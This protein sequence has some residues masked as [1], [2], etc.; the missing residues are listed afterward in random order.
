MLT[1]L[2]QRFSAVEVAVDVPDDVVSD[3]HSSFFRLL[4]RCRDC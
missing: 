2:H 4:L 3:L 1:L